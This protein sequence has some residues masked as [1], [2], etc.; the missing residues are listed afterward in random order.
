MK[1]CVFIHTNQRQYIGAL[2]SAHSMKRNSKNSDAFD[3]RLIDHKDYPF[4]QEYEGK[5]YLRDGV[6]RNWRNDDLQSF[7]PLRFMPPELM[8]YQGRAVVVDPDVFAV[9][10]VF[11]LLSR[12]MAGK[13]I[14]CRTRAGAKRISDGNYASSVML[15]ECAKLPTGRSR[16]SSA[17]CSRSSAI[18]ASG[19]TCNTK[20]RAPSGRSSRSG[21]TSTG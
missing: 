18:T 13:A 20:T 11:E 9:G 4:F 19:S 8:G 10:D 14:M 16:S 6:E 7:T 2:V 5:P 15:L 12:D 3:V 17:S 21:T 1:P